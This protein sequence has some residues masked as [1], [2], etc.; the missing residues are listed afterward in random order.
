MSCPSIKEYKK[1][2]KSNNISIHLIPLLH[3]K[4]Y[5][6]VPKR[7]F[8]LIQT[9]NIK[10]KVKEIIDTE[11]IDC[12]IVRDSPEFGFMANELSIR[13]DI[14][15]I[16]RL[17]SYF[18]T[19][20]KQFLTYRKTPRAIMRYIKG[21]IGEFIYS[22]LI[23]ECDLFLPISSS[24][25][26]YYKTKYPNKKMLPVTSNPPESFI[27]FDQRNIKKV[28]QR[29]I[30][31]G[32]ISLIRDCEFF[33]KVLKKV[34][35]NFPNV[36]LDLVG[37]VMDSG[38]KNKLKR[39]AE[40]EGV[41]D[42]L[43]FHGEVEKE[44]VPELVSSSVIGLSPIPPTKAYLMSS[45]TKVVEYI[46]LG[47]PTVANREIEDQRY[48][49]EESAGGFAVPYNTDDFA[50]KII[51]LLENPEIADKMGK[52]G[53]GWIKRNRTYGLMAKKLE[54]ELLNLL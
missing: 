27:N 18:P 15:F 52:A 20:R 37:P 25:K 22:K 33:I 10:Q 16:Y 53:K 43:L 23:K 50:K 49:I 46:A 8:K 1:L 2:K 45:P 51:Y 9:I 31:V 3:G 14:R 21:V 34:K 39:S 6:Y 41:L 30:Y 44:K 38:L 40:K 17:S 29:L 47:V 32:Q 11:G 4:T 19:M 36:E 5:G 28:P 35:K 7:L 13:Y 48:V 54:K 26:D 24:M 42:N 12:I